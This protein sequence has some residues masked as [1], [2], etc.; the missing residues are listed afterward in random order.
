MRHRFFA[1]LLCMLPCLAAGRP[2]MHVVEIQASAAVAPG[3][4]LHVAVDRPEFGGLT[5]TG[6][7]RLLNTSGNQWVGRIAVQGAVNDAP[8]EYKLLTRTTS[9]ATHCD[10][11][12][13]SLAGATLSTNV[14]VWNPGYSG[15]IIYY[16]S[17]WTNV[18]VLYRDPGT[19]NWLFSP[20]MTRIGE[21]RNANE[22]RYRI[23]G[24]GEAGRPLEF[25]IRGY[26]NDVAV[27]DNP[28]VGG[29]NNNYYTSL[30]FF[31]L[32]DK[33]IFNYEPPPVVSP[34][35][36][37]PVAS[38][39]SSYTANGIPSRGGRIY[40]P[41][42]Y[43]QNTGKQYPVLYMQDGQNVF[44]PGGPFGSWSADA[45]ATRE[46]AQG[47]MRETILV[48]VNNTGSRLSEYGTPQD[49]HTGDFYLRYLID[50]VKSA[51]DANYRTLPGSMDT[52]VMGSSLGGLISA[53]I[54]LSTNVFGLVGAVSP[55]YW[56]GPNFRAWIDAQP[57]KGNRIYQD[58][59]T[60]EGASMWNHF[61]PVYGYYLEDGY[62]VN[63]DLLVAIG[64]GQGHNE[65]AWASRVAGAFRFLFNPWDEANGLDTNLPPMAPDFEITEPSTDVAV[66]EA[67]DT[68]DLAGS[69]NTARWQG[70]QWT[71]ALTGAHGA[72]PIAASWS[73]PGIP[74]GYG[75]NVITVTATGVVETFD[76][77]ASDRAGD[78]AY[79]GGW[80]D[81][82]NGGFGFGAWAL[83]A[84]ANAGRF[85]GP[86]GWGMWAQTGHLSEAVRPLA[87]P[88][89][90]GERLRATLK[91]GWVLEGEQSV[92]MALRDASGVAQ[93]QFS[94]NGGDPAYTL[95]D[96]EGSRSTGIAWTDQPQTVEIEVGSDRT[97]TLRVGSV[98]MEGGFDGALSELRF[99]NW[100]GGPGPN[101]DF[102]CDDIEI[103]TLGAG[104]TSTSATVTIDRA[105]PEF[106]D[107]IPMSWW[108][109]YGLG[110]NS[111]ADADL[112]DDGAT[113]WEEYIAD[114]D[115]TDGDSF[116]PSRTVEAVGDREI[117][118][119]VGPPTS[120]DRVY[121]LWRT[122]DLGGGAWLR[123]GLNQ[124]GRADGGPVWL[125]ATNMGGAVFYRSGVSLP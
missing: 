84:S 21:G 70:L 4:A 108:N 92:G 19:G 99:W 82:S 112:D 80:T 117:S 30:D 47:R 23:D 24:I 118:I 61:W 48:A 124:P 42:G 87:T 26:T 37:V 95:Q 74:L 86:N 90:P 15:K 14:P 105:W 114:T 35:Q 9:S 25:V 111:T 65:A 94:F 107:G 40:L 2:P 78:A 100:S 106:H 103:F 17:A 49:G 85:I 32:Q 31:F 6:A 81:G 101:Y 20:P 115:P 57:T 10:T 69:A 109:R 45:A 52:G 44:D 53:Y 51:V 89:A 56:Y 75:V 54:G 79:T 59:G 3:S 121:D 58:A 18:A 123:M 76:L 46:I 16:H 93:I 98:A 83:S 50:D 73:L 39:P 8:V 11:A 1:V 36:V 62:A 67:V 66:E 33:Q 102:F 7:V 63:D 29:I 28:T 60:A 38:W 22:H 113:N 110:T 97:Y 5:T 72:A 41:R 71:N 43:A 96:A 64:C 122:H 34:P 91:N 27:W 88:L 116:F 68:F 12:N 120:P 119:R 104:V 77:L 13:G 125:N 55:S